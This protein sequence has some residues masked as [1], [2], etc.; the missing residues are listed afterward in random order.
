MQYLT[1]MVVMMVEYDFG[2]EHV[3]LKMR[4]NDN[5]SLTAFCKFQLLIQWQSYG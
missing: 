5:Q 1:F 2:L 4:P 3:I